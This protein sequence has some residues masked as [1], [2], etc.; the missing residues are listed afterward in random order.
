MKNT[1]T[2]GTFS[3]IPDAVVDAA[4]AALKGTNGG[5]CL[6]V[7]RD[8][9]AMKRAA[10]RRGWRPDG[11]TEA[12][13]EGVET[14]LEE[15]HLLQSI[16]DWRI[17]LPESRLM[18]AP[19]WGNHLIAQSVN[20]SEVGGNPLWVRWKAQPLEITHPDRARVLIPQ[21]SVE[22]ASPHTSR[23]ERDS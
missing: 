18:H 8:Y 21:E 22:D 11:Y 20:L 1:N 16:G 9:E 14:S 3:E 4:I 19:V 23:W 7:P 15:L 5:V 2:F 12:A 6:I 17:F 13:W 10:C